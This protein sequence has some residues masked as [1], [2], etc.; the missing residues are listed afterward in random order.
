MRATDLY[1]YFEQ[2][3]VQVDKWKYLD[4]DRLR[5]VTEMHHNMDMRDYLRW[6]YFGLYMGRLPQT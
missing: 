1:L 5:N 6:K 3:R 4:S 2:N